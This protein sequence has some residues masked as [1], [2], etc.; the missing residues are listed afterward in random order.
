MG[1][2]S[3]FSALHY[4]FSIF[5]IRVISPSQHMNKFFVIVFM[6]YY[7][8]IFGR[9]LC[10]SYNGISLSMFMREKIWFYKNMWKEAKKIWK[11]HEMKRINKMNNRNTLW[12]WK[13]C[14]WLY[15]YIYSVEHCRLSSQVLKCIVEK[16]VANIA[17]KTQ[18]SDIDTMSGFW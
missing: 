5:I 15:I 12:S 10:C 4:I 17:G 2:F 9:L 6:Y 16:P 14:I 11:W 8:Y 18:V 1:C 3:C 7:L 13:I